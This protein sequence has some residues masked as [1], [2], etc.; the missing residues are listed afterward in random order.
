MADVRGK[1]YGET[2]DLNGAK[3]VTLNIN[4]FA[5]DGLDSINIIKNGEVIKTIEVN[6]TSFEDRVKLDNIQ[7]T[8]WIVLEGMGSSTH[9]CITNPI[10]FK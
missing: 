2:V 4:A 7:S 10:F 8:D 3:S 6:G 9:Y 1:T 5:R